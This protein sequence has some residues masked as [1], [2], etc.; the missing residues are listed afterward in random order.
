MKTLV[1]LAVVAVTSVSWAEGSHK[2]T[3]KEY[4]DQWSAVAV[5]QMAQ[6]GIPAS[7]TLAQGI[8]ESGNGNS[9]LAVKG[10]NH[11]GIKCHGWNGKKMYV[12]DDA[13]DECF[14]VYNSGADSYKDHSEFLK[15]YERYAF[16]FEYNADDYKSWARGLKSAGYATNPKYPD[17]LI[18]LIENLG[19]DK[20]DKMVTNEISAPILASS[21]QRNT[22]TVNVHER[23]VEYVVVKAGDTYYSIAQEFGL[24]LSQL[25][26]FN[27]FEAKKDF[28]E[29]GDIVYVRAKKAG[30][31]FKKETEVLA[32]SMT[33]EEISQV[34]AI[35]VKTLRRL[36]GWD[37]QTHEIAAGEK[38]ILR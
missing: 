38:I 32:K 15:T 12:D 4:V 31:A 20:Y 22:H 16:L 18:G 8:L 1:T 13:K 11:F 26:R 24:T 9:E 33:V 5:E 27:S 17:L 3:Q 21:R 6:F 37:E 2:I 25:Y 30:N 23:G 29:P 36:N 34:Y 14:R 10:N 7:I 28:L 35:R 19:L